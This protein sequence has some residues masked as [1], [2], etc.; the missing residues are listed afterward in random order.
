MGAAT[1]DPVLDEDHRAESTKPAS[2]ETIAGQQDRRKLAADRSDRRPVDQ[3]RCRRIR[4]IR[5]GCAG[6]GELLS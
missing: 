6:G 5:C 4:E 1:S 2:L 3:R